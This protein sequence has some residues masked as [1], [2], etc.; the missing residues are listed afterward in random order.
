MA[1]KRDE[2]SLYRAGKPVT[3]LASAFGSGLR[4]RTTGVLVYSMS[5]DVQNQGE[6]EMITQIGH[7]CS[8]SGGTPLPLCMHNL[9]QSA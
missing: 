8:T 5:A 7:D 2:I 3:I 1:S 9:R 4:E 6:N